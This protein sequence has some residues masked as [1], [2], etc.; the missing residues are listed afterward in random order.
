MH[1]SKGVGR[2]AELLDE[3]CC[4]WQ[5]F[6]VGWKSRP[7]LFV[8]WQPPEFAN[9]VNTIE[10]LASEDEQSR[11]QGGYKSCS[12]KYTG[13][14]PTVNDGSHDRF[15]WPFTDWY[16]QAKLSVSSS[17]CHSE[18]WNYEVD[19]ET[20][21]QTLRNIARVDFFHQNDW[22]KSSKRFKSWLVGEG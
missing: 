20:L 9:R 5:C 8:R 15:G 19:G 18:L 13:P 22:E 3:P 7:N 16:I 11:F 10:S 4:T 21:K 1:T 2:Q 14:E 6:L 12:M 17:G